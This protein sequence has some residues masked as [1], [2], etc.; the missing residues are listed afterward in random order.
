MTTIAPLEDLRA[1]LSR[2]VPQDL[3]EREDLELMRRFASELE[4]PFSRKQLR[5]HFT[6]S[7]VVV[8]P[9]GERVALVLH[10]KFNRWLQPGGHAEDVDAG[11]MEAS[12]LREAREETGCRVSL[13]PKAPSP[14]DVDVHLISARKDEPEHLHL[15]VRFLVVAENPEALLHD[16]NESSGAQWFGW[17][18]ALA[19]VGQEAA[20]RR[21]ME[22]ARG[23]VRGG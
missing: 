14:L 7:A 6:G 13:H 22:K 5:A 1:L 4:R 15:D 23:V 20:L 16:P 19:R 12:A 10:G 8:D 11:S 2:H 3:K 18:E 17:D 9:A 21:L